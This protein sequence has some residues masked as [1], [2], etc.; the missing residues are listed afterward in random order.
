LEIAGTLVRVVVRTKAAL[1]LFFF[2]DIIII[3]SAREDDD[4]DDLSALLR[5]KQHL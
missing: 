4:D 1:P 3:E 5:V 2:D